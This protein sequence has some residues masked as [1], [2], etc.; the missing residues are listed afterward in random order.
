MAVT[1]AGSESPFAY[2]RFDARE[3]A[4]VYAD[5][6]PAPRAGDNGMR[7]V[8]DGIDERQ[9]AIAKTGLGRSDRRAVALE[10]RAPEGE[11]VG[12]DSQRDFGGE[13]VPLP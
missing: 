7:V 2:N 13:T 12:S 1:N 4:P 6:P 11:A 10:P 3:H 8:A 5:I 9:D